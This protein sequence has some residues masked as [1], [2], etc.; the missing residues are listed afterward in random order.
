MKPAKPQRYARLHGLGPE[1][2]TRINN[3]LARGTPVSAV[4]RMIQ[5]DWG[6]FTDV[7]E[8]SLTQQLNRYRLD[9]EKG[10]ITGEVK[11]AVSESEIDLRFLKGKTIDV[12]EELIALTK[13]QR[14][15]VQTFYNKERS[16][17]MPLSGT[18]KVVDAYKTLL[19][20][21]QKVKFDL[22]LDKYEGPVSGF[23]AAQQSVTLP[24]GTQV[25]TQ[26][27]EAVNTAQEIL[28][29]TEILMPKGIE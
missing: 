6:E 16:V 28:N 2:L 25:H 18:D 20:D 5:Q 9:L 11:L 7:A 27:L 21:I 24:N 22:G 26:V 3:D 19:L 23:R 4:A 12:L 13:L 14:S 10:T 1:R 15:R 29:R 17:G 8:T